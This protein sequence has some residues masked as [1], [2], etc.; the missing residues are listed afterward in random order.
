MEDFCYAGG[1]PV[2]MKEIQHLLHRDIVTVSGK[3]VGENIADAV[4][5]D[6]RV[7]KTFDAPFKEKAG[8]CH[9]ARQPGTARRRHQTQR[10]H[11]GADGA[12]RPRRGV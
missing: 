1:L 11:P 8:H 12:H 3:T 6:P 9:F 4:N 10:G 7:I 2:V 5:Y